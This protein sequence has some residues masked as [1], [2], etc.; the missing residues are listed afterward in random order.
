MSG[1]RPKR[2][3]S[4]P[5]A[6]EAKRSL[7]AVEG[8]LERV[9]KALVGAVEHAVRQ[10]PDRVASDQTATADD[11]DRPNRAVRRLLP[12]VEYNLLSEIERRNRKQLLPHYITGVLVG[13][14]AAIH[15]LAAEA[16]TTAMAA[17][18]TLAVTGLS[19]AV[20]HRLLR[21]RQVLLQ[22]WAHWSALLGSAIA[23]WMVIAVVVGVNWATF[24]AALG[25]DYAFGARWWAYHRHP[26]PSGPMGLLEPAE[27]A[28]EAQ[29]IDESQLSLYPRRWRDNIG[30]PGGPLAGS[31]LIDGKV[32]EHGFEYVLKLARAKQDLDMVRSMMTKVATGLGHPAARLVVED[33]EDFEDPALLRFRVVTVSP[34]AGDV[35]FRG[36]RFVNGSIVLG[37]Y[38][39][40]IGEALWRLYSEDSMWGGMVIGGTGSGKSRLIEVIALV[41]LFTEMTYVIHVDGQDG[42]SCPALWRKA[43]ERYRSD[44]VDYLLARLKAMQIHRQRNRPEDDGGF[45]PSREYPG[46][47]VVVDEAHV[48]I[49]RQNV[50]DWANLAR[51]AR[52]VGIAIIMGD[53]DGSLETFLKAVLRG[54][55]R[56][57]NAAGLRTEERSHGQIVTNGKFNLHDLP[58]IPGFGHTLGDG[59]R[60][61]PYRG[62]WLP[63]RKNAT[64]RAEAGDPFPDELLLVEDWYDAA[65]LISLDPA[66]LA[67]GDAVPRPRQSGE[68]GG[69][70]RKAPALPGLGSVP[71]VA[72][73]ASAPA[74]PTVCPV[75]AGVPRAWTAP[76]LPT[77]P[78]VPTAGV[79]ASGNTRIA[80]PTTPAVRRPAGV[81]ANG[82]TE[83]QER[84]LNAVRAGISQPSAIAQR[85]GVSR[86][87]V[88]GILS[89][90]LAAGLVTK[91]GAGPS[92]CYRAAE[93]TTGV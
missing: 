18:V 51:Q 3:S 14:G 15:T 78:G 20:A 31:Q 64:R 48:V 42:A 32:F 86:Q 85:L 12:K 60:H 16:H 27:P 44:E 10:I 13:L 89:A 50:D 47:L 61:A 33:H 40:G 53:Q 6:S 63:S 73:S 79:A 36:P 70:A 24:A 30:C 72:G 45:T 69:Q 37:P 4:T 92:V 25:L 26:V 91:T 29:V 59:A 93:A 84:V 74:L 71:P 17:L 56:A 77:V 23:L 66:T 11:P 58:K 87:Y 75:G 88:A 83:A 19:G 76:P 7:E 80:L 8:E 39:D 35:Y 62:E 1:R 34:V 46:I 81:D 49:T 2:R 21:K 9:S 55:L 22:S 90:L 57:G 43:A 52:K 82:L 41:A 28:I 68:N 38:V 5:A 65:P 67:A 54:S